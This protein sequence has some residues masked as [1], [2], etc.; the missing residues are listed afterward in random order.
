MFRTL[1][2]ADAF[3][4]QSTLQRVL[5]SFWFLLQLDVPENMRCPECGSL[6]EAETIIGDAKRMRCK[7]AKCRSSRLPYVCSDDKI[8]RGSKWEDRVLVNDKHVRDAVR[9]LSGGHKGSGDV[10]KN[11]EVSIMPTHILVRLTHLRL[12]RSGMR[13]SRLRPHLTHCG[14]F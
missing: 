14:R 9:K 3:V 7:L 11:Q 1:R 12:Y 8:F 2:V 6:S 4:S 13:K 10:C 5:W